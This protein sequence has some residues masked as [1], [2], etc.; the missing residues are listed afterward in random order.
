MSP[1]YQL[2]S[3]LLPTNYAPLIQTTNGSFIAVSHTGRIS[4]ST[5]SL[6]DTYHIPNL[7]LISYLL[8][9]YVTL[10]LTC[11]SLPLVVVWRILRWI[12]FLGYAIEC[13]WAYF[14]PATFTNNTSS[15]T[16]CYCV[17]CLP[18]KSLTFTP[19]SSIS[20]KTSLFN[21]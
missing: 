5:F 21:F 15:V 1:N 9:N 12:S 19:E 20:S 3:S 18:F 10:V 17:F 4:T 8:V 6:F 13:V 14:S 16:C 7:T 11:I 2:F